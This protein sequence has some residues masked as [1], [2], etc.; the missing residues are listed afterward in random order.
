MV[1]KLLVLGGSL[2]QFGSWVC[3]I[4]TCQVY[5]RLALAFERAGHQVWRILGQ[6]GH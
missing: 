5:V 2:L 6:G 4:G 1:K 3:G